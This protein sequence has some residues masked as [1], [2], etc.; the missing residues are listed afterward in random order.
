MVNKILTKLLGSK[1][2]IGSGKIL[3]AGPDCVE[4]EGGSPLHPNQITQLTISGRKCPVLKVEK[5]EVQE[6][7]WQRTIKGQTEEVII[8]SHTEY[9]LFFR[10]PKGSILEY[11]DRPGLVTQIVPVVE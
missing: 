6:I 8:P 11:T 1:R 5:I 2:Y 10:T 9:N 4:W 3:T 7:S